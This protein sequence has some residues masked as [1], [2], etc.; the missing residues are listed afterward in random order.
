ML[1][2]PS[3]LDSQRRAVLEAALPLAAFDGWSDK[4]LSD[5]MANTN[6]PPALSPQLFPLGAIDLLAFFSRDTDRKVIEK[7]R[8]EDE[9]ISAPIPVKINRAII[10]RLTLVAP[11]KEAVRK[12]MVLLNF[13]LNAMTGLKLLNETCDKI[14][15]LAGDQSTDFNWYTKR[16]TLAA[17]YSS[18][19][20]YWL[21]DDSEDLRNTQ[22]FLNRRMQNVRSFGQ[23]IAPIKA[24]FGG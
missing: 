5:A 12:G 22:E 11:H 2:S 8:Q 17:V 6:I 3:P 19:L 15:R 20:L 7:L 10:E 21:N 14:W 23:W 1:L 9:F 18:T 24:S 16:A 13:P 4:T